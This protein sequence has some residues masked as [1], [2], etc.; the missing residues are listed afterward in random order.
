MNIENQKHKIKSYCLNKYKHK[1]R[2]YLK[3]NYNYYL[4]FEKFYIN[5]LIF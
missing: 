5:K 1:K 4:F 2:Q 3:I